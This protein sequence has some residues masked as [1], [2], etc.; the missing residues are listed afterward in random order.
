MSKGNKKVKDALAE[1]YG[2][3]CFFEAARVAERLE[4][5]KGIQTY[6]KFIAQKRYYSQKLNF[7]LLTLHHLIHRDEGG[8]TNVDNGALMAEPAHQ[9]IHSLPREVEEIANNMMREWK[10]NFIMM[11]G[12]RGG[13]RF[14]KYRPSA[15][16]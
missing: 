7:S 15:A 6:K 14:R 5:I 16:A 9:Y 12:E 2:A 4:V 8:P 1:K 3:K 11:S 10:L 13:T